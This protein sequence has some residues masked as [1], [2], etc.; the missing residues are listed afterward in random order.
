MVRNDPRKDLEHL[1]QAGFDVK[2][3]VQIPKNSLESSLNVAESIV[4]ALDKL[5]IS[6]AGE[7]YGDRPIIKKIK[8]SKT[9]NT[10][11][12]IV[13]ELKEVYCGK[14]HRDNIY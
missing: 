14:D 5:P 11:T 12:G 9:F 3:I 2:R 4:N 1:K 8:I 6:R 10:R 13:N 7:E